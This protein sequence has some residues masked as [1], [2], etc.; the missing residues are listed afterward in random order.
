[1]AIPKQPAFE[2]AEYARRL[3]QVQRVMARRRL[4]VLLLFSPHNIFYL[5]GMDSENLF[6]YQCLVVP[7]TDEPTLVIFDFENA[8]FENSCWL[9]RV[10]TYTSFEDP[11]E[12]TLAVLPTRADRVALEKQSAA[13]S[14]ERFQQITQGLGRADIQDAFGIVEPVRLI[15]SS[16]E[17]AYMRK[18]A[19]LTDAGVAAGVAA[20]A[21]GRP[22]YEVAA[23]I[24]GA[25][26]RG[27]GE[28]VCWGPVVAAGY[29]A[30]SA[31]STFNG[32]RL[33]RGDTVFFEVTG[34]VRRYTGPLMRTAILGEPGPEIRR[35]ASIVES[36]VDLI[37]E[38]ARSGVKAS[39]VAKAALSNVE[40]LLDTMIFH[41][42]FGYPVGIG[43]P[44]S[45]IEH[46]GYFI[47]VD[48]DRPLESGMVFH[49]P[50]SFRKYGEYGVNLSQTMLVGDDG[51]V[52]LGTSPARLQVV[53]V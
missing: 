14:V 48:N 8:R 20:L 47:R 35:V 38:K 27:G 41:H 49:L 19:E 45:W 23:D 28:T 50:M 37:L 1:M 16:A 36:T 52:P 53:P 6:D 4:D 5:S 29:R 31:H 44:P 51:G 15:K 3:E 17:V 11:I 34:E 32:Y 12:T 9:Q 13:V 42:Y 26:Y 10:E 33:Q 18:A 46:L 43:Y 25:M 2:E 30:G 22:D 21:P 24:M 40:P 7:A 39:D